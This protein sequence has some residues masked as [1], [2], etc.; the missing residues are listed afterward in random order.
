MCDIQA[1]RNQVFFF[2][3]DTL[4]IVLVPEDN[5]QSQRN[6]NQS[7]EEVVARQYKAN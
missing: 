1:P 6:D 3:F 7:E 5:N 4:D 2:L